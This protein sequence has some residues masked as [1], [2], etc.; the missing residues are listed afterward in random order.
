M[1]YT[2]S[3]KRAHDKWAFKN[4]DKIQGYIKKQA[5][6]RDKTYFKNYYIKNKSKY[7][8]NREWLRLCKIEIS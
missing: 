5:E 4:P 6:T 7:L 8:F 1:V 3:S 2:V